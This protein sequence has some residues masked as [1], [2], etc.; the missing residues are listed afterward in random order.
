MAKERKTKEKLDSIVL[1]LQREI[2]ENCNLEDGGQ[3]GA[4]YRSGIIE[5]ASMAIKKINTKFEKRYESNCIPLG[6]LGY[7]RTRPMYT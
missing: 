5:G 7:E 3:G 1:A 6:Y 2:F 4:D